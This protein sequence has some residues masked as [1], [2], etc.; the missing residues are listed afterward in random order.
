MNSV[1]WWYYYLGFRVILGLY[2]DNYGKENGNYYIGFIGF[3]D[4]SSVFLVV[5]PSKII[6]LI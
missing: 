4:L 5:E 6:F 2:R 3:R 1:F